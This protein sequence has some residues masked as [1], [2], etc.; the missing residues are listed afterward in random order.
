MSTKIVLFAQSRVT[1]ELHG[2]SYNLEA[3][4]NAGQVTHA[5]LKVISKKK[6]PKKSAGIVEI[7]LGCGS[8][9]RM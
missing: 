8:K 6:I 3:G 9:T 2:F 5:E 4:I 1:L 7:W